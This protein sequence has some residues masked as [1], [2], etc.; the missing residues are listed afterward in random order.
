M[1]LVINYLVPESFYPIPPISYILY[2]PFKKAR[3][4]AAK[5]PG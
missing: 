3:E 2:A 1:A 5:R 4:I